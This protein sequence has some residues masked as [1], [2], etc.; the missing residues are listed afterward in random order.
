MENKEDF[1]FSNIT[2]DA[3]NRERVY[4][5]GKEVP[6]STPID[7]CEIG[8]ILGIERI[9]AK[10][11]LENVMVAAEQKN[12]HSFDR[13]MFLVNVLSMQGKTE[14]ELGYTL[15]AQDKKYPKSVTIEITNYHCGV[16]HLWEDYATKLGNGLPKSEK[17]EEEITLNTNFY[18]NR[19]DLLKL[20]KLGYTILCTEGDIYEI[21]PEKPSPT[22]NGDYE[23]TSSSYTIRW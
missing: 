5:N 4:V 7:N 8:K 15:G 22:V 2:E 11:A 3:A 10:Q 6:A 12:S 1:I 18:L 14:L 9:S 19:G 21:N 23:Y 17:L 13:V 16:R 20:K